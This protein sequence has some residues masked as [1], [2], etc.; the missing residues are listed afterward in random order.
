MHTRLYIVVRIYVC[1]LVEFICLPI[2]FN[3][4]RYHTN[5]EQSVIMQK[6]AQ[7]FFR[8]RHSFLK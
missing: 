8:D 3:K 1:A 6:G 7:V 2:L 4:L 5:Y